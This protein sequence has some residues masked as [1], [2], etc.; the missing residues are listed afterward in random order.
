MNSI[1]GLV[2]PCEECGPVKRQDCFYDGPCRKRTLHT[3]RLLFVA[4]IAAVDQLAEE[5][6]MYQEIKAGSVSASIIAGCVIT[7]VR[8]ESRLNLLGWRH[9]DGRLVRI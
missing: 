5:W 2:D 3:Q 6:S 7:Q 1:N 9:V 8:I 4:C